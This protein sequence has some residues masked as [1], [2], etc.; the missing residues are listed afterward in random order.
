MSK[1]E[2]VQWLKHWILTWFYIHLSIT[3]D[4]L[5]GATQ[6]LRALVLSALQLLKDSI[7]EE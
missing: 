3:P 6:T 7:A 5:H 4:L 2:M 1:T